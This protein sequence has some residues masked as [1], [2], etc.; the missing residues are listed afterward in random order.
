MKRRTLKHGKLFVNTWIDVVKV[1]QDMVQAVEM[2][3]GR[4]RTEMQTS[5]G[6]GSIVILDL[7]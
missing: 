2:E 1:C 7:K 3:D 5:K 4:L 6:T